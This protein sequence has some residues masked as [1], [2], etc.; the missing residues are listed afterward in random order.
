MDELLQEK[1]RLIEEIKKRHPEAYKWFVEND[2]DLGNLKKYAENISL[3][4]MFLSTSAL[5]PAVQAHPLNLADPVSSIVPNKIL[6]VNDLQGLKE[7]ER[8]NL[9]WDSYKPYIN[10]TAKKYNIP[11]QVIL[12]TIMTESNGNA[13]AK[14]N[15]PQ[16]RDASYGVGQILYGTA[17]G[18]GFD[19]ESEDLYNPQ[20][21]IDLIGKYHR[22]TYDRYGN[23][24]TLRQLMT[25]Y[26]AGS[27]YSRA[28]PGYLVRYER[29]YHLASE[30]VVS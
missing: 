13:Y 26:N 28:Y 6:S 1:A 15:E 21:N 24:L 3:A 27:P 25:G 20:T 7:K 11:P 30:L 10:D 14:R 29:W 23:D 17:R 2:I 9:V 19:G 8:I 22:R 18:L 12:T 16:I 5:T 4:L